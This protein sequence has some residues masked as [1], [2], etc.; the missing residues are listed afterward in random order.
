MR[1]RSLLLSAITAFAVTVVPLSS[2]DAASAIRFVKAYVNSPGSDTGSNASLNAEYVAIK[3]F[4]SVTYTIAGM[5][6]RDNTG[7]TYTFK[8]GTKIA[9]GATIVIHTGQGTETYSHKYYGY[10]WYVWNNA[11]D[12]ARLLKSSGVLLDDCAWGA[13]AS[14]VY[15]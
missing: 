6:V 13:V 14:Y 8:A 5:K 15:C 3:N 11:G 1:I 10:T 9:P 2:A 12:K 4:G 7:Y